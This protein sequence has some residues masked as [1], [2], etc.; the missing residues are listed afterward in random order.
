MWAP[1]LASRWE[2]ESESVPPSVLPS[3]AHTNRI[4]K[5]P[6]APSDTC[7]HWGRPSHSR[8]CSG[9]SRTGLCTNSRCVRHPRSHKCDCRSRTTNWEA[10]SHTWWATRNPCLYTCSCLEASLERWKTHSHTPDNNP[11]RTLWR[12]SRTPSHTESRR[13]CNDESERSTDSCRTP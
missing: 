9:R 13:N 11:S 2:R 8:D 3:A 6:T 1:E 12:R 5:E 7:N 4:V 10:R